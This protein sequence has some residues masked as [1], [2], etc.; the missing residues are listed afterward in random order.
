MK[1]SYKNISEGFKTIDSLKKSVDK[2][3]TADDIRQTAKENILADIVEKCD[4][5]SIYAD[6]L[7][8]FRR[9]QH[10][11]SIM[12]TGYKPKID[13]KDHIID[14]YILSSDYINS[15]YFNCRLVNC[16]WTLDEDIDDLITKADMSIKIV[17][18][19]SGE[20]EVV[21]E[22][23]DDMIRGFDEP[24]MTSIRS[25]SPWPNPEIEYIQVDL[26]NL[27]EYLENDFPGVP[28][29]IDFDMQY[30]E[31]DDFS[32]TKKNI[33]LARTVSDP[34]ECVKAYKNKELQK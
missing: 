24:Y 20:M 6:L 3:L 30:R 22:E 29:E 14:F 7:S 33:T 32:W 13:I 28:F 2:K 9:N 26:D 4:I 17:L 5:N 11:S 19:Y 12:K 31:G 15:N 1:I 10:T 27:R 34:N 8:V 23:R 25:R 18:K 16:F 21:R